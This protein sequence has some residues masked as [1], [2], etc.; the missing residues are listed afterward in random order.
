MNITD[1][2]IDSCSGYGKPLTPENECLAVTL[3]LVLF[4]PAVEFRR[5]AMKTFLA[6]V[7]TLALAGCGDT[8]SEAAPLELAPDGT[9]DTGGGDTGDTGGT[10]GTGDTGQPAVVSDRFSVRGTI[11][12]I[13]VWA[14]DPGAAIE[15]EAP[16]G[17]IIAGNADDLGSLVMR[18]IEPGD[19]YIVRLAD[20]P[21]ERTEDVSVLSKEGSLPDEAFYSGQDLQPGYGYITMRDGTQLSIFV[22]L[23]GPPEDGPYPTIVNYSGYSPS[24]PGESLGAE[25]EVFCGSFPILCDAPGHPSGLLAGIAG[26]ASVGVNMRGTGCSGGAYDFFEPLQLTDGYDII[27]IVARQGWV[28]HNK[29][30]MAGLSYPGISQ[31]F[32]AQTQPPSLAAITP[33]SVLADSASSTLAPGGIYNTGFALSWID[34]VLDRAEPYG[35]AWITKLVEEG[36]ALCEDNQLL[37]SAKVDVVAKA[38]ANPYYTDEVARPVDPS[39]WVDKIN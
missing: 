31:L 5:H 11:E 29:V 23:P 8:S 3:A 9:G 17:E 10:G 35:H 16:D 14:A 30:G 34:N 36:D 6:L 27:E 22:S 26:Y 12:Q 25:V 28:K 37:H 4:F 32:V 7:A 24:K 33:M 18:G 19:G 2:A 38:L 20:E 39:A 21:D 15:V 1:S 13:Y